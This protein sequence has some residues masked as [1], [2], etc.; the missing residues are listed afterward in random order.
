MFN[1]VRTVSFNLSSIPI[2]IRVLDNKHN[3]LHKNGYVCS[4]EAPRRSTSGEYIHDTVEKLANLQTKYLSC[5]FSLR[6]QFCMSWLE[7]ETSDQ[8]NTCIKISLYNPQYN[9]TMS[10]AKQWHSQ[11]EAKNKQ[12]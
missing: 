10:E 7:M 4:L 11:E 2:F 1:D 5:R 9:Y 12:I 8:I 6:H 3:F